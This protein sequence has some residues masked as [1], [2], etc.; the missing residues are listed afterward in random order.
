MLV[1]MQ[2][3]TGQMLSA[4][5]KFNHRACVI[6]DSVCKPNA[7]VNFFQSKLSNDCYGSICI[8][9]ND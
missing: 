6:R 8:L 7:F 3:Q 5:I 9:Q 2:E 4:N 1:T